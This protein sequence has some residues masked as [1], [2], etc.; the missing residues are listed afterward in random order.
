MEALL[1]T[2]SLGYQIYLHKTTKDKLIIILSRDE[3]SLPFTSL[4]SALFDS[5]F[6][7]SLFSSFSFSTY[8]AHPLLF[9]KCFPFPLEIK[10]SKAYSPVPTHAHNIL[11]L[12]LL[13]G[14]S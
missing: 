8:Y 10:L 3:P 13:R 2:P 1:L 7:I 5:S 4:F 12:I 9:L 6:L 14:E 11:A